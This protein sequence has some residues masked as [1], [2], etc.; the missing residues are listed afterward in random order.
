MSEVQSHQTD[1]FDTSNGLNNSL[2][3]G[4]SKS[5]LQKLILF[6]KAYDFDFGTYFHA[7]ILHFLNQFILGP[8]VL[9]YGILNSCTGSMNLMSNFTFN[10]VGLSFIRDTIL[11][12]AG[13]FYYYTIF[14]RD[15]NVGDLSG[16]ALM[17]IMGWFRV[18]VV[19]N[20]YACLGGEYWRTL[21]SSKIETKEFA[22][23]LMVATWLVDV[24][25]FLFLALLSTEDRQGIDFESSGMIEFID[26][27]R[28]GSLKK[29][30]ETYT[31]EIK[32]LNEKQSTNVSIHQKGHVGNT[33]SSYTFRTVFL[34]LIH[35]FSPFK[36]SIKKYPFILLFIFFL[37]F[38]SG[39]TRV[40]FKQTF[41]GEN[42]IEI[43]CFYVNRINFIF[44]AFSGSAFYVIPHGD[45]KRRAFIQDKSMEM[46]NPNKPGPGKVNIF[47]I[48]SL[49]G[50]HSLRRCS[51]DFAT[52]HFNKHMAN[53]STLFFC[54]FLSTAV[55]VSSAFYQIKS[56]MDTAKLRFTTWVLSIV[57]SMIL[58]IHYFYYA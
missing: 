33:S 6:D 37:G 4:D 20:K 55:H 1:E 56:A 25:K 13:V 32:S 42:W 19:G 36:P 35:E 3:E 30:D 27:S 53:T 11:W 15:G 57:L 26:D 28:A 8:F 22:R 41:H 10:K 50:W 54:W 51:Q 17:M 12:L 38:L 46:A 43:T 18:S 40:I 7:T 5:D 14:F 29:T 23:R 52:H 58:L 49:K 34:S 44:L 2:L 9:I 45:Y 21:K 39:I 24:P 48:E 16:L 31:E 47:D